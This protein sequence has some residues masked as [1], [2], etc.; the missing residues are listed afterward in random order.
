MRV[1]LIVNPSASSVSPRS[2]RRAEAVIQESH[3]TTV[4]ETKARGHA[5]ELAGKGVADDFPAVVVLGGDG[6]V[7]EAANGLIGTDVV[8]APLPGG[9]TNVFARTAGVAKSLRRAAPQVAAALTVGAT[10]PLSLGC[11]SATTSAGVVADRR[12]LFHVGMGFD[13]QVVAQV[14]RRAALKRKLGQAVFVYATF[15]TWL[16]HFDRANPHFATRFPDGSSVDDGYYA[17]CLNSNPYT[18]F[19]RRPLN[20]APEADGVR[21][22]ASFTVRSVGMG[23][24]VSLFASALRDGKSLRSRADV[25]Y[26][27][28]LKSLTVVGHHPF[29]YQVDGDYLGEASELT[30]THQPDQIRLLAVPPTS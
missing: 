17:V 14:E 13:A 16:R 11:V 10:R 8:L 4:V 30:F 9:S 1:L 2:R 5:A 20:L 3:D 28:D 26:H 19:G 7:N 15:S 27:C 18:Y 29:S 6:T 25:D 22:L 24:L 23:A 21:G 12:F